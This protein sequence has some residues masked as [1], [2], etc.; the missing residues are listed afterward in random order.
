M[1]LWRQCLGKLAKGF[2]D[3]EVVVDLGTD[4]DM[5]EENSLEGIRFQYTL[6]GIPTVIGNL[7]E[8]RL[9]RLKP[10]Q[11]LLFLTEIA[12]SFSKQD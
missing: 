2:T 12:R 1:P 3:W 6:R 7:G 9:V 11:H 5:T 4:Y 8:A 10:K